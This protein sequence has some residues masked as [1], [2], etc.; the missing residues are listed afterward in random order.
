MTP[1]EFVA[2]WK[3]VDLPEWAA[4]Q[5]HF[6]DLCHLLGQPTPASADPTGESFC[7]EKSVKVVGAAS[8]GSKGEGG[9][10]DV[11][12]KGA[13]GWEYKRKE[14]IAGAGAKTFCV[15]RRHWYS[16]IS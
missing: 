5:E 12:K 2:K 16:S 14:K 7:F 3:P 15:Y 11:W 10:V 13:F 8:K 4:S 9:F 1:D 6:L